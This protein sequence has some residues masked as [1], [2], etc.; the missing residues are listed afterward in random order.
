ML[1]GLKNNSLASGNWLTRQHCHSYEAAHRLPLS[2][3]I[4]EHT[5][6]VLSKEP[7]S[8]CST[9]DSKLPYGVWRRRT[10]TRSRSTTR[11]G[12]GRALNRSLHN[13]LYLGQPLRQLLNRHALD[14]PILQ[15]R[16]S[17]CRRHIQRLGRRS[18]KLGGRASVARRI[19]TSLLLR[20]PRFED[21]AIGSVRQRRCVVIR[22]VL[23]RPM[24][25]LALRAGAGP[26]AF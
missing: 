17:S 20:S 11:I 18:G 15:R 22:R 3:Q 13:L 21:L 23:A 8:Q 16:E 24:R 19:K 1:L 6:A 9:L 10:Q 4:N 2:Y 12:P 25:L 7:G 14:F 26:I 5:R